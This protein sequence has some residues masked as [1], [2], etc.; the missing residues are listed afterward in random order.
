M[1]RYKRKAWPSNME[2][3]GA[4]PSILPYLIMAHKFRSSCSGVVGQGFP[5]WTTA[6]NC[7]REDD[8]LLEDEDGQPSAFDE[9]FGSK[10]FSKQLRVGYM[11][12]KN[13]E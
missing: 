1:P 10:P 12:T 4:S 11:P 7:D 5:A 2:E 3:I 13:K 9:N 6:I 8:L